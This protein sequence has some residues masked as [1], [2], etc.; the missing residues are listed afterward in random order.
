MRLGTIPGSE[1]A[2]QNNVIK[3]NNIRTA[4][5]EVVIILIKLSLKCNEL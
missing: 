5:I 1:Q 2:P 4:E 3:E